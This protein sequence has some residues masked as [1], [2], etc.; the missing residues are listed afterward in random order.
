MEC[1]LVVQAV[2]VAEFGSARAAA[3]GNVTRCQVNNGGRD[4]KRRDAP[5]ALFQQDLVFALDH[6]EPADAAADI[7]AHLFADVRGHL[8]AGIG[9]GEI[10]RRDG[11]LDEPPHLLDLFFFDIGGRIEAFHLARNTARKGRGIELR[12][13]AD[14]RFAR[15]N[16]FPGYFRPDAQ[17]SHKADPGHYHSSRQNHFP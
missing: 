9:E 6:L 4:E 11:E 7:H 10:R 2:A 15:A 12:D 13:R 17:R 1:A 3:D 8:E 5:R 16:R 14:A